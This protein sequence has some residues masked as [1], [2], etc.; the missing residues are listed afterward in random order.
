MAA[1]LGRPADVNTA[2]LVP[3]EALAGLPAELPRLEHAD[4]ARGWR[5]PRL[6]QLLVERLARVHVDV[7]A[8]EVE[9]RTRPHRPPRSVAQKHLSYYLK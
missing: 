7:G 8:D 1:T 6:A 3:V 2:L 5:H 9:Q 4:E